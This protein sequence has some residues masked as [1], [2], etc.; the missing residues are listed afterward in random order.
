MYIDFANNFPGFSHL[1]SFVRA[2]QNAHE[3]ARQR[4]VLEES[5]MWFYRP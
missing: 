1:Q 5:A 2:M 4:A 3:T